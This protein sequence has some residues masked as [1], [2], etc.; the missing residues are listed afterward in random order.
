MPPT[1]RSAK[2]SSDEK[3]SYD[4]VEWEDDPNKR[5][6]YKK[7]FE[8]LKQYYRLFKRI[9]IEDCTKVYEIFK[10][11][12][13][14]LNA[15]EA[16]VQKDWIETINY[17]FNEVVEHTSRIDGLLKS[18]IISIGSGH[19]DTVAPTGGE[20]WESAVSAIKKDIQDITE[21]S[22]ALWDKLSIFY[23]RVKSS[24]SPGDFDE[25]VRSFQ[26]IW[27]LAQIC[28]FEFEDY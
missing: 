27:Q 8:K 25:C 22:L 16:Y 2:K 3:P 23:T 9:A 21:A 10:L 18:E 12:Y 15:Y 28:P 6:Q 4:I 14:N 20:S 19:Y 1:L 17:I 24:E 5:K 26:Q 7:E 13:H 11:R